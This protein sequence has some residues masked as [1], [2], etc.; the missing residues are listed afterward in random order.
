MAK[1]NSNYRKFYASHYG[2]EWDTKEFQ[3]HHIDGNR[4]NNSIDNL[5]LLPRELHAK[6]HATIPVPFQEGL[7]V[8][9]AVKKFQWAVLNG[10][11]DWL[12]GVEI[13]TF[14][15][16]MKECSYWGM[17]K[18]VGYHRCDGTPIKT[19]TLENI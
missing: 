3:V 10:Y 14:Y 4:E 12:M 15:D 18:M 11:S 17:L 16:V 5:V 19:I 9:E 7:T 13:P 6:I 2:I 1:K 8:Q